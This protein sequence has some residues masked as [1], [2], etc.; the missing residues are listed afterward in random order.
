MTTIRLIQ[1][2]LDHK[3]PNHYLLVSAEIQEVGEIQCMSRVQNG[4]QFHTID[5]LDYLTF[6]YNHK[7]V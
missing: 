1:K 7:K 2:Y 3:Y 4:N 6:I 5:L